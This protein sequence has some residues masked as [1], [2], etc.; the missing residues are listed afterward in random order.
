MAMEGAE[1]NE[2]PQP[3]ASGVEVEAQTSG[4]GV[5]ESEHAAQA[6]PAS[7]GFLAPKSAGDE[8]IPV[9]DLMQAAAAA[10]EA[11]TGEE[12]AE[13]VKALLDQVPQEDLERAAEA[14]VAA[15]STGTSGKTGSKKLLLGGLIGGLL[16]LAA[17]AFGAKHYMALKQA[18]GEEGAVI[19]PPEVP[20]TPEQAA[21]AAEAA[22]AAAAGLMK[23][24]LGEGGERSLEDVLEDAKREM[25]SLGQP[26]GKGDEPEVKPAADK[27]TQAAAPA[28]PQAA[29]QEVKAEQPQPEQP[30]EEEE[31]ESEEEPR[32]VAGMED[33]QKLMP[34]RSP[35]DPYDEVDTPAPAPP[36]TE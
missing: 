15:T 10:V 27:P 9:D 18:Q 23:D 3:S 26:E 11:A 16:S 6:A 32:D 30:A 29:A 2:M 7:E 36:K 8:P 21:E 33:L 22:A 1:M 12:G 35:S 4:A 31:E 20:L 13:A 14:I 34:P 28:P 19:P 25:R 5:E 17:G 24:I